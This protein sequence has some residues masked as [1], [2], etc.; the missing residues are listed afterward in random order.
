MRI[1]ILAVFFFAPVF[2][3]GQESSKS[4][5]DID[6]RPMQ[7]NRLFRDDFAKDTRSEYRIE[8]D[9]SWETGSLAV[10]K[11]TEIK[12]KV[13]GGSIARLTFDLEGGQTKSKSGFQVG[14]SLGKDGSGKR[15][16]C[17]LHVTTVT[18]EGKESTTFDLF[19][20]NGNGSKP[21]LVKSD[22]LKKK[23]SADSICI[24]YRYGL[25]TVFD[26]ENPD[27]VYF[28]GYVKTGAFDVL[29][30]SIET[31]VDCKL[32]TLEFS[33]SERFEF[34]FTRGAGRKF[35]VI[36]KLKRKATSDIQGGNYKEAVDA[37]KKASEIEQQLLGETNLL[38]V[39]TLGDLAA[40]NELIGNFSRAEELLLKC[41]SLRVRAVGVM[42]PDYGM[43]LGNLGGVYESQGEY[44]K[45]EP[46]FLQS[47]DIFEKA[48]GGS[49]L[50]AT[51]VSNLAGLYGLMGRYDQVDSLYREAQ[52]IVLRSLGE[53]HSDY[54]TIIENRAGHFKL[55]GDYPKAERLLLQSSELT[56]KVSN[57]KHPLYATSLHNL[58]DLYFDKGDYVKAKQFLLKCL[59]I[60]RDKLGTN[61]P[62]YAATLE[63]VGAIY[64]AV[65]DS[66]QAEKYLLEAKKILESRNPKHPDYA[67]NLNNLASLY[68]ELGSFEKANELY[69]KCLN[70]R[71]EVLGDKHPA[72]ANVLDNL[73]GNYLNLGKFEKAEELYVKSKTIRKLLGEDHPE[74][75][76]SL[77]NLAAFN[78]S[79][80]NY[81]NAETDYKHALKILKDNSIGYDNLGPLL[82]NLSSLY[83]KMGKPN[84]AEEFAFQGIRQARSHFQSNTI[85]LSENQ[86]FAFGNRLRQAL[87]WYISISLESDKFKQK[88]AAEILTWKG[89]ASM[90]QR[91]IRLAADDPEISQ[92]LFSLQSTVRALANLAR[93]NDKEATQSLNLPTRMDKLL[94]IKNRIEA[95]LSEKVQPVE[96]KI[97]E[98]QDSIPQ[99]CV[100]IDFL[101]FVHTRQSDKHYDFTPSIVA[102]V[103]KPKGSRLFS[104]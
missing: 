101:K 55:V 69:L 22:S 14:F 25:I 12:R 26:A 82:N 58:A 97:Q 21:A 91:R 23:V 71:E 53:E 56:K 2:V 102:V 47:R 8:G 100:L 44:K 7:L 52:D 33:S 41:R 76:F 84:Q 17:Q 13:K 85:V 96:V 61:H 32:K 1:V 81:P 59:E 37:F 88:A 5:E 62:K 63:S 4:N 48:I 28:L 64:R 18:S 83:R 19:H 66:D 20:E 50:H 45:A 38:I 10:P 29:E 40:C 74:Y 60:R 11:K 95:E 27:S 92:Q 36:N 54:G 72:Y 46:C 65:G 103:L 68:D 87:D 75:A 6:S 70:I 9:V 67:T 51:A 49:Q 73:A 16:G 39:P 93:L 30:F 3:M 57:D 43:I 89:S 24:E 79:I 78:S 90:H 94:K 86:Q 34:K 35:G 42:H 80:G 15:A 77:N 99:G 31:L 98:I 104:I